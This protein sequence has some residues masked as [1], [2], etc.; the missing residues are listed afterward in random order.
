MALT[1]EQ[2]TAAVEAAS[3]ELKFLFDKEKVSEDVS[4]QLYHAGVVTV[5]QFAAFASGVADLKKFDQRLLRPGEELDDR[6]R[7]EWGSAGFLR[8]KPSRLLCCQHGAY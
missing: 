2:K 4:A 6:Q 3:S 5:R 1:P 8:P 7:V